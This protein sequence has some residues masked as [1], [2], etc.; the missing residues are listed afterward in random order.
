MTN[1]S[2]EIYV[3]PSF[4]MLTAADVEVSSKWYQTV[5]GFRDVFTMAMPGSK[6]ILAHLRWVKYADL[7]I[8]ATRV[9]DDRPKGVGVNLYF[10]ML[11]SGRT[12]DELAETAR[13][14]GA[15][16]VDGPADKPWNTR[17]VTFADPDGFRLTFSQVKDPGRKFEQVVGKAKGVV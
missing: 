8:T 12:V 15:T 2:E 10:Q 3:M 1:P 11:E 16:V 7:L 9:P 14:K 17:E 13:S 4:P 5:L 6:P